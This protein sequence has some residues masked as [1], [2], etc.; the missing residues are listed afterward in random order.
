MD[1]TTAVVTGASRGLGASVAR[2]FAAEGAHVVI[3]ARD[4]DALSAVAEGEYLAFVDADTV[5]RP[6]YLAEMVR[7]VGRG[8]VGATS[9]FGFYDTN[10]LRARVVAGVGNS[11]PRSG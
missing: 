10:S 7:F 3:C 5:V 9:R 4:D 11:L 8:L 2:L 6:T 1:D